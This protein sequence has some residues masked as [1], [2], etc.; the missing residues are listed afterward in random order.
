MPEPIDGRLRQY[1]TAKGAQPSEAQTTDRL[2]FTSDK[3]TVQ[4]IIIRDEAFTERG[5]IV[6]A[7]LDAATLREGGDRVYVAA[8][9]LFGTAM[10]ADSFQKHGI[11]LMIFD[12]KRISE[13]VYPRLAQPRGYPE[14]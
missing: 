2:T 7:L 3:E 11:G 14:R 9:A 13:V 12:E 6:D 1:F 5:K 8:S 10:D 4:V